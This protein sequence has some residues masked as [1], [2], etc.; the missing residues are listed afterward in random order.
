LGK[1]ETKIIPEKHRD[2]IN[3][4]RKKR[5]GQ[6]MKIGKKEASSSS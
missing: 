5:K 6:G 1:P 3:P 2:L 4:F